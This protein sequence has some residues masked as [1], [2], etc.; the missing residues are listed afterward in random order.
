MKAKK[1]AAAEK[2]ANRDREHIKKPDAT[3]L[4]HEIQLRKTATRGGKFF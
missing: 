1:A 2:K 3:T 4:A